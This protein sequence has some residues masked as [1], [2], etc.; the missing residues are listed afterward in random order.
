MP[1]T[2]LALASSNAW[3][4]KQNAANTANQLARALVINP[5]LFDELQR[6]YA[7]ITPGLL[8]S[9]ELSVCCV[10]VAVEL[11]GQVARARQVR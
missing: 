7:S 3:V 8:V 2:Y 6:R 9:K 11:D 10:T 5:T 1:L 4:A